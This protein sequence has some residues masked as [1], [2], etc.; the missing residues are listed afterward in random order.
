MSQILAPAPGFSGRP[1]WVCFSRNKH[2]CWQTSLLTIFNTNVRS[3]T[4]ASSRLLYFRCGLTRPWLKLWGLSSLHE[5]ILYTYHLCTAIISG[6]IASVYQSWLD[7]VHRSWTE[8][9]WWF[10]Q[11]HRQNTRPTQQHNTAVTATSKLKSIYDGV[12]FKSICM[13]P[14]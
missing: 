3:D 13:I 6:G 9:R 8:M 1:I 12:L 2:N 14:S 5:V 7:P 4:S 11:C 10:C